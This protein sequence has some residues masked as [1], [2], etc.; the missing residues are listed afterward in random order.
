MKSLLLILLLA[1]P[2]FGQFCPDGSCGQIL[3]QRQ[4]ELNIRRAA[5]ATRPQGEPPRYPEWECDIQGGM[6]F[7]VGD[8]LVVTCY[9]GPHSVV[10]YHGQDYPATFICGSSTQEADIA[11][12]HCPSAPFTQWMHLATSSPPAGTPIYWQGGS[13][14]VLRYNGDMMVVSSLYRMGDSGGPVWTAGGG[15]CSIVSAV[16]SDHSIGAR[17]EIIRKYVEQAKQQINVS[18][19]QNQSVVIEQSQSQSQSQ[20]VKMIVNELLAALK[21]DED[22]L[23]ALQGKQGQQGAQGEPGPI[24]PA[25]PAGPIGPAGKD[26]VDGK[27]GEHGNVTDDQLQQI[28]AGVADSLKND[29]EFIAMV[30]LP[31][32]A[33]DLSEIGNAA[34]SDFASKVWLY[35]TAASAPDLAPVDEK[36]QALRNQGYPII[37]TYLTPQQATVMGVPMIFVPSTNKKVVGISNC[38]QF[39]A[40]QIPR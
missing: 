29:Q 5:A 1:A 38:T 19:Q 24:G 23:L 18:V 26:G 37:V 6:G 40:R 9:H 39:L 13:G 34:V 20:D 2:A 17:V 16:S 33:P 3:W 30:T 11:I 31:A 21:A 8:H 25:G 12:L 32:P 35:Y 15:V 22:L 36:I 7:H 10:T 27:D 4:F 28:V 14:R